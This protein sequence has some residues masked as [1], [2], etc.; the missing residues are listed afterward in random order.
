MLEALFKAESEYEN[1][2]RKK[3]SL[4]TKVMQ[5]DQKI[6]VMEVFQGR[7]EQNEKMTKEQQ[8][9]ILMNDL[10]LNKL[11]RGNHE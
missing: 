5:L 3:E 1:L 7:I 4:L 9:Q 10:A 11:L 6:K 8:E 2:K